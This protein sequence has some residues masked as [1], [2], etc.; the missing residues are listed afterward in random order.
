MSR[1]FWLGVLATII[2]AM[3]LIMIDAITITT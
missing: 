3:F 2:L 1:D